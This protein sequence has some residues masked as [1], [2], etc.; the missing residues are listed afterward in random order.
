[1]LTS[2]LLLSTLLAPQDPELEALKRD[3]K[4]LQER[5]AALE[6]DRDRLAGECGRLREELDRLR[7]FSVEAAGKLAQ[8]RQ[9]VQD[10][11]RK[12]PL[13]ARILAVDAA[14]A[15]V[16]VDKGRADGVGPGSSFD[17]LRRDPEGRWIRLGRA[18]YD[19]WANDG[20]HSKLVVTEGDAAA[21]R[22]DDLAV[23]NSDGDP[24]PAL[25]GPGDGSAAP[26]PAFRICGGT[27]DAWF[28]DYGRR[29]GARLGGMVGVLRG[30][31][32]IARL[33]IDAVGPDWAQARL[34]GEA[35]VRPAI[36][37]VLLV[38]EPK[39]PLVGRVKL[40][41]AENGIVVD[42]GSAVVKPG[43]LFEI[44]R[45]G[46]ALGR[47]VVKSAKQ[48]VAFTEPTGT[49]SRD[50]VQVGDFAESVE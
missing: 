38:K 19:K 41:T 32:L 29:D 50:D 47:V 16:I 15:F 5:V 4:S 39:S 23:D 31:K 21:L 11:P 49:L 3:V 35:Q 25:P 24:R 34:A 9:A 20:R 18:G 6:A 48:G 13:R 1:M 45:A 42:L 12:P 2:L 14:G 28:L 36:D 40:N 44:R 37:D 26:E 27:E 10:A 43:A 33:R 8:L 7:I 46:K 17:L 22:N 30:G